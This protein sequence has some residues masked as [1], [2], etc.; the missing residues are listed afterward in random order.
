MKHATEERVA[1]LL[2]PESAEGEVA[3][4]G[5]SDTGLDPRARRDLLNRRLSRERGRR[6]T[7]LLGAVVIDLAAG[8]LGA[9]AALALTAGTAIA[10]TEW[11]DLH[12]TLSGPLLLALAALGAYTEQRPGR[13][14]ERV[15]LAVVAVALLTLFLEL[16]V[17]G[18]RIP[19]EVVGVY[20]VIA[21]PAIW[22]GRWAGRSAARRVLPASLFQRR[23]LILGGREHSWELLDSLRGGRREGLEIIGHLSPDPAS[24][25]RALGGFEILGEVI[26]EYDIGNVVISAGLPGEQV[27]GLTRESFLHGTS[28]SIVPAIDLDLPGTRT[29]R[30][31]MGW[32]ALRVEVPR[33][34][35]I[36]LALKRSIDLIGS[37]VGLIFLTP[38]FLVIAAAIKLSSP[39][40]VFFTQPRP[41][42]GGRPFRMWKFRT[43]R[44]DAE[45]VLRSDPELYRKFLENDCKLP[46]N[47]DPRIFR[48]GGILRATSLDELPQLFNVVLGEMSLVGPRPL[49]GPEIENY[50]DSR[51]TLLAARP[52]MTGYW[53][54][55]GRS[56][57]A[58]PERAEMDLHYIE[59]WS[60]LLDLKILLQTIPAVVMQRG[61]H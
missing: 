27:K 10:A 37:V 31:V 26:E 47:E 8:A 12:A 55:N 21:I 23:A 5:R 56:D 54:V 53:Q 29:E 4:E 59:N 14:N 60:L 22:I 40:P 34:Y 45:E 24:D 2:A 48:V 15:A 57:V 16:I 35:Q 17:P 36:Q 25:P 20:A 50:G 52:G 46:E 3:V 49:I 6:L 32:P 9:W 11:I 61:A 51:A 58:Y 28:V 43:M 38:L 39:G 13:R 19:A 18:S 41:G 42:L 30:E 44:T 7:R 33:S 1:T